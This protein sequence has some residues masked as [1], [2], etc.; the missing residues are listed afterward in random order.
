MLEFFRDTPWLN[1][2]P[3]RQATLTPP[4][5]PRCGLLGG[6]SDGTPKLSKLQALAAARRKK[7]QDQKSGES[8][9][10]EKPMADLDI[11]ADSAAGNSVKSQDPP[12]KSASRGFPL[13]KRK[14]SNPHEQPTQPPQEREPE[15]P[16]QDFAD[17]PA[18]DQASPSAF[19]STMFGSATPKHGS[20][21]FTLPYNAASVPVIADPFA[22]PSPDD[23]VIAAQS[24]SKGVQGASKPGVSKK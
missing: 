6:A 10:I 21:L 18:A 9:G 20:S 11:K 23:V 12:H 17:I 14:D 16:T 15:S 24:Q 4:I 3:H 8:T 1:I 13:R 5:L 19:A 2:P 7:A 22:G